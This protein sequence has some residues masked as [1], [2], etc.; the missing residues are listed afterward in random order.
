MRRT[1]RTPTGRPWLSPAH[2]AG[3]AG[4][5]GTTVEWYDFFIFS[6]ASSLVF[7]KL[8]FPGAQQ[9]TGLL[10]SFA[11]FWVSFLGRPVG[12]ALFGH[13]GDRLG[14]KRSL[15]ATLRRHLIW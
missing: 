3:L 7:P 12:A 5:V 4:L 9:A 1:S 13:F 2:K 10:A 14:R 15:V 11:T 8:F 6:T